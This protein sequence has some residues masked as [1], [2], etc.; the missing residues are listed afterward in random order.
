MQR[1]T[2]GER[3]RAEEQM[4]R[5]R[6][7]FTTDQLLTLSD[8]DPPESQAYLWGPLP[9]RPYI[10]IVGTRRPTAEGERAARQLAQQLA[11]R[12]ATILSGGAVGIDTAAHEGALSARGGRTMVVAPVWLDHAHP[13]ANRALFSRI[14]EQGGCYLTTA[15]ERALAHF[16]TFFRRNAVMMALADVV[17]LGDCGFRSGARNAMK[18]ARRL[19]RPRYCLPWVWGNPRTWGPAMELELGARPVYH[20]TRLLRELRSLHVPDNPV[21][22]DALS[23]LST[24]EKSAETNR[25]AR[26]KASRPNSFVPTEHSSPRG[27]QS[28]AGLSDASSRAE[29]ELLLRAIEAGAGSVERLVERTGLPVQVVQHQL[30]LLTLEG[31]VIEDS[32]GIL[33]YTPGSHE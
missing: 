21:W 27:S 3:T 33:R 10:A 2:Q 22:L 24:Q 4:S 23:Q 14:L 9:P 7:V 11:E 32:S 29:S 18:E 5:P 19:G 1:E 28:E 30:T 20:V 15:E 31:L 16:H 26:R 8:L 17:I 6:V 25:K 13:R 12:G